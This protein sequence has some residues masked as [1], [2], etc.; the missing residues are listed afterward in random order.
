MLSDILLIPVVAGVLA[1]TGLKLRKQRQYRQ[2]QACQH[3]FVVRY[4]STLGLPDHLPEAL[5]DFRQRIAVLPDP[6]PEPAFDLLREAALRHRRTERSY[7]PT[8]KQGGTIAYEELHRTAP[9]IVAF[10]QSRLSAPVVRGG[11]RRAGVA[12]ADPRSEFLFAAVLRPAP[13]PYRLAL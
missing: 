12:D 1:F 9:E 2:L 13:R 11:D 5:P 3:D 8:H 6:L 10:Y 7:F 4:S